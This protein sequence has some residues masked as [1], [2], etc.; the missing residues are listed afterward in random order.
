M[1]V[2]HLMASPFYGGPERQMLGLAKHLPREVESVF[3]SFAERGQAQAL[4]DQVTQAG[5]VGKSLLHNTPRYFSCV[6]EVAEELRACKAD[7]LCTSGYKPDLVGWRAARRAGIPVVAVAHGWTRA[8][9]R[10][11][12]YET[13]DRW[14]L[15]RFDAVVGVSRAQADRVRDAGVADAKV[16]IIHNAVGDDAFVEP[17]AEGR[18]EMSGW[19]TRPPRW[20]VGAAGRLS[21]EKGYADFVEAATIV[22]R[23]RPDAGFVLFGDGPL[24]LDLELLITARGI[25]ERFVLAGFRSDLHRYLPNLDLGVMSSYTEGLPVVLL[26]T[27]AAGVPT[28]ATAVGG[29]PEVIDDG[30]SG[31]LA[32][33]GEPTTLAKHMVA[34]LDDEPRRLSMGHAARDRVRRD[35]SFTAMSRRYH[36]LFQGLLA[37]SHVPG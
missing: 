15:R 16:A 11:R 23:E 26:E 34:L 12:L 29:I 8:T 17:N 30:Q 21:P 3:L 19:F 25:K 13:L 36:E 28:V 10:V 2:V 22:L 4:L 18:A 35:F 6:S 31:L 5:F 32:P 33:A 7:L 14:V 37:S 9:W 27:G 20:L 24:R 1:R